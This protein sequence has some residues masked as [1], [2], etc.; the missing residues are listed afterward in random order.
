MSKK[1][2]LVTG[3]MGYIGTVLVPMLLEQGHTV[4]GLDSCLFERCSIEEFESKTPVKMIDIRDITIK[5]LEGFDAV[6]H[7]AGLSNDPLG[8]YN[9]N[10][11]YA[12]NHAATVSLAEKA[13]AAGVARFLFASSCG[14]YGVSGSDWITEESEFQP[15]RPYARSKVLSE[16][17]LIGLSDENFSPVFLRASTA[18]G[19]SPMLRF[20]LVI[21]NL[22][23]WAISTNRVYLKSTGNA[24]RP[25]VHIR[26][27]ARAYI[28]ALEA[29][30]DLVHNEAF[31]VGTTTEN[32]RVFELAEYIREA[33]GDCV[34][35]YAPDAKPDPCSYRV[36]C[37]KI[38]RTLPGYKPEWTLR[39]GVQE[40][41]GTLR[42]L[43]IKPS[44]FEGPRFQRLAHLKQLL[45]EGILTSDYRVATLHDHRA[46]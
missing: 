29:P 7:L 28:A 2:V 5:D 14:N 25:V 40:L 36:D 46:G 12:I 8:D 45:S 4:V 34:I 3:N 26:D 21:N 37:N 18:Y 16:Q 11:T 13:K 24:W 30:L 20:D 23:A 22:T 10:L 15:I 39:H 31:N 1:N 27:I 35:E 9:E 42:H 38:A 43:E 41:C 33:V 44:D 6:I 17:S 32:Y 19:V